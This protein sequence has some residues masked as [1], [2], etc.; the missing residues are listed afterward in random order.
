MIL[1]IPR[2]EDITEGARSARKEHAS[3]AVEGG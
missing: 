1:N 3:E 2:R